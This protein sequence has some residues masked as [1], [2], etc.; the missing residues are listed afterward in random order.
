MKGID[1]NVIVGGFRFQV[2]QGHYK[3]TEAYEFPI[4]N[5]GLFEPANLI[6]ME[7]ITNQEKIKTISNEGSC[8]NFKFQLNDFSFT[9]SDNNDCDVLNINSEDFL[10]AYNEKNE[11]LR[12]ALKLPLSEDEVICGGG[13]RYDATNHYGK[14]ISLTNVDCWSFP[15]YS[16]INVPI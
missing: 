4:S 8:L 7:T 9:L 16:Y 1:R 10:F 2:E 3:S 12:V 15:E 6:N 5:V 11:L 14:T 13:E